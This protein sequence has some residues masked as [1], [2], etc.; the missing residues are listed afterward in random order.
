MEGLLTEKTSEENC[1]T[2]TV[3]QTL[4]LRSLEIPLIRKKEK[5][6]QK[7]QRCVISNLSAHLMQTYCF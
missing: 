5:N 1:S 3:L 2:T 4:L 7:M 6:T